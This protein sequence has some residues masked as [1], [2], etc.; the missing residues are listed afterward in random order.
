[1]KS[2]SRVKLRE[3]RQES[4]LRPHCRNDNVYLG[5][6]FHKSETPLAHNNQLP[7]HTFQ[8]EPLHQRSLGLK[9]RE[10]QKR[11]NYIGLTKVAT[12]KGGVESALRVVFSQLIL[13]GWFSIQEFA[14]KMIHFSINI[15]LEI[16]SILLNNFCMK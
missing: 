14:L 2:R 1:M 11:W 6:V 13:Q 4:A 5:P 7:R 15:K 10:K 8:L 9:W 12:R 16:S 3:D